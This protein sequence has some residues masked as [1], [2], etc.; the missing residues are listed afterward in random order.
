MV[1]SCSDTSLAGT[2]VPEI[3]G[4]TRRTGREQKGRVGLPAGTAGFRHLVVLREGM[5]LG[6]GLWGAKTHLG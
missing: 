2:L 6:Q 5:P 3:V 4:K 1:A